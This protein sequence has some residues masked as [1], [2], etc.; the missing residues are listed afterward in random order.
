MS[1]QLHAMLPQRNGSSWMLRDHNSTNQEWGKYIQIWHIQIWYGVS[2]SRFIQ[3]ENI[4]GK[5]LMIACSDMN[6]WFFSTRI[7]SRDIS[8]LHGILFLLDIYKI[9]FLIAIQ[10]WDFTVHI[11]WKCNLQLIKNCN[12]KIKIWLDPYLAFPST[13]YYLHESVE[14]F[15]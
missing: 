10:I 13:N 12:L 4:L 5:P 3:A 14:A 11:Y 2:K 15:L 7:F 8:S 1:K 6:P 9:L